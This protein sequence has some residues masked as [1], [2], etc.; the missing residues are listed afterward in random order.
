MMITGSVLFSDEDKMR[1]L[2]LGG[3]KESHT[4]SHNHRHLHRHRREND[5]KKDIKRQSRIKCNLKKRRSHRVQNNPNII[6]ATHNI[7]MHAQGK[8]HRQPRNGQM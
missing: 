2:D 8:T 3:G 4:P 5:A 1:K 7:C 6:N